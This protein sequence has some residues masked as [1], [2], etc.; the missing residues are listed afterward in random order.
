MHT[1]LKTET[2]RQK[3]IKRWEREKSKPKKK[4]YLWYLL[5]ILSLIYIADEVT[6]L[7][8]T[9]MQSEIAIGLFQDRMSV[10]TLLSAFSLPMIALSVFYRT[11]A[12]KYGRKLFICINTFG[13]GFA[14]FIVFLAGR[15][16]AVPGIVMYVIATML[17]NFFVPNDIQ[18]V[19][20]METAPEK[21]RATT[22]AVVKA[23]ATLG[24]VLIPWMRSIFMGRDVALWYWVYLIPAV[25][26]IF[27]ALIT[28][29][30]AR[31]SDV[32][33]NNRLDFLR[34]TEDERMEILA[35]NK[36]AKAQ[37]GLSN[38]FRFA[39]KHRQLK[40]LFI[41]NAILALG[42]MG[43]AFYPRIAA[44]FYDTSDVTTVLFLYPF[45]CA[46]ITLFNG[47]MSD[48]IGRKIMELFIITSAFLSFLLFY[49]GC[50]MHWNPVIIGIMAGF[51]VG[52]FY[53]G[54]DNLMSIMTSESAPTN[55]RASV[56][57]AQT[58]MNIA[59]GIPAHLIPM[60]VLFATQDNYSILG[61]ACIIASAPP[62]AIALFLIAVK[63]GDTTHV[64]M[65]TVRGDE[66][67]K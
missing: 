58:V 45:S 48:K 15:T 35:R 63:V 50:Q 22:F 16:G 41:S 53:A 33:I 9:Q 25:S 3:E 23:L 37:G 38:A 21:R 62:M 8:G 64:D 49:T 24:V 43:T 42:I 14:L 44:V 39:F 19:Y 32:F 54:G 66:W 61:W 20:L 26:I 65:N 40:W 30:T 52:A 11:L 12:D 57:S 46:L 6:T 55:L 31:E 4:L 47:V 5:I 29:L 56:M 67:D 60:I 28:V 13:M 27:V 34:L 2:A 36:E 59:G 10:M 18:A 1:A 17:I 51:Y 7:I